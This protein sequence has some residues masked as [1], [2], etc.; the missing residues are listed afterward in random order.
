MRKQRSDRD[1]FV[2]GNPY[3]YGYDHMPYLYKF[4]SV[5]DR[6]ARQGDIVRGELPMHLRD[7]PGG[8]R[9]LF[10]IGGH[11]VARVGVRVGS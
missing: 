8:T 7:I 9:C 2:R 1:V 3:F 10:V 5:Q 4:L 6:L 11:A